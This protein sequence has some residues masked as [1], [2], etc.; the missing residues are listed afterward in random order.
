MSGPSVAAPPDPGWC[1]SRP[2]KVGRGERVEFWG[3]GRVNG[4]G[5][6]T[7]QDHKT[8]GEGAGRVQDGGGLREGGGL[9]ED[10]T[11]LGSRLAS[12]TIGAGA[13]NASRGGGR[14]GRRG[15]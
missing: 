9:P 6:E 4:K 15:D 8:N 10:P 1:R 13:A 3:S 2:A 11:P 12:P 5:S 7:L 14:K